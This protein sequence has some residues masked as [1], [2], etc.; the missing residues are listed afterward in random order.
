MKNRMLYVLLAG[1]VFSAPSCKKFVE[2]Q[3]ENAM[4]DIV[5]KGTWRISRYTDHQTDITAS[6]SGYAFQFKTD[7]TVDGILGSQ[8]TAGTWA[9]DV[10]ART[11]RSE[12]PAAGDPLD[13]LN[14]TWQVTDS[15]TDS[16][17]ART[18]LE[19]TIYNYLEL[20]KN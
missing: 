14:Y 12:F 19:G 1:A 8:T 3:K 4:V 9:G 2:Q 18:L 16:V 15:Y 20:H 17:S 6:F 5:T 11:I 7:G 10:N 13:K